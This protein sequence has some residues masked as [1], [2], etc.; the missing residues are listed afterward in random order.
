[1]CE[2]LTWY[3]TVVIFMHNLSF[4]NVCISQGSVATCLR[5]GG[6]FCIR[7]VGN[8]VLFLAVKTLKIC[9]HLA[10]LS[11]VKQNVSAFLPSRY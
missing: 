3:K 7:L 4:L 9:K 8:F 11:A 1:M 2:I 6:H 5:C 10:Q